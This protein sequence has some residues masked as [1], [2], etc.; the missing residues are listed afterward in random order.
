MSNTRE[1]VQLDRIK[2]NI[3]AAYIA[4]EALGMDV[5]EGATVD[6]LAA[7]INDAAAAHWESSATEILERAKESGVFDGADGKSIHYGVR[8]SDTSDW[9]T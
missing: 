7:L 8:Y 9:A 5:P 6:E 2:N 1:A 3:D 4:L